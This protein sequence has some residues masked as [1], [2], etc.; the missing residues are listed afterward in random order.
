MITEK[1]LRNNAVLVKALMGLPIE[2][3]WQM[4]NLLEAELPEYER[5]RRERA[6]RQRAVGAGRPYT[7]RLAI[8]VAMVLTYARLHVPQEVAALFYGAD[9]ADVSRDLRRLLPLMKKVLPVPAVWKLIEGEAEERPLTEAEVLEL[10][11]LADGRALVD[12]TEQPVYRS[13]DNEKRKKYYSGKKKQFMLKT[14]LVTDGEH[15][16]EAISE[17]VPGAMNDKK[18]SDKLNTLERLPD[19][20]EVDADKGYQGLAKQVSLVTVCNPE[21]G[22]EQQVPRLQVYTPFKK[23]KGGQLTQEQ[24]AF[25]QQLGA[26]RVRVEHC[27]GWVKNWAIIATRFRCAH[28]IYTLV[29]QVVCGLVNWQTE[30]W[31]AAKA[32]ATA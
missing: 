3:F 4:V 32:Q 24:K 23:P 11:Q 7:H 18:L 26:I 19:G 30:R 27:I 6:D 9:Q 15:H 17:A 1:M 29:M 8:R 5:Q 14:Q 10:V 21:T 13:Q 12:A 28:S 25:N 16:I 20:C 2:V 31:Q 22:E